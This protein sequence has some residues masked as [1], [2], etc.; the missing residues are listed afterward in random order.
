[1]SLK[2]LKDVQHIPAS[3][4]ENVVWR[5]LLNGDKKALGHIYT[6]YFQKLYNYGSRIT[7]DTL[8]IEDAIQDLFCDIWNRRA[9]L[10]H[11]VR[12]IKQYLYICL[13]RN[14]LLKL[15]KRNNTVDIGELDTFDLELSHKSHY[16]NNQINTELRQK[17]VTMV[18]SLTP[19]QKEA[20]FLIYFDELSYQEASDIMGLKIKTVYNLV[21]QA[22]A[23]L[24]EQ[25][26]VFWQ[27]ITMM[28]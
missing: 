13:R 24:K 4:G 21:H 26:S 22:I 16:L 1:V 14:I 17:L 15:A 27:M 18:S 8:V 28:F 7:K 12:N 6:Q 20:I 25:K 9:G 2:L 3:T 10:N 19:K 5:D 11:E 23:R